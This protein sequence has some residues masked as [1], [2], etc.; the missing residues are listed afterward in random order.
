MK[1]LPF[2]DY[3]YV[4]SSESSDNNI[5]QLSGFNKVSGCHVMFRYIPNNNNNNKN[6]LHQRQEQYCSILHNS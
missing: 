5:L 2:A 6:Y 1:L 3:I 4:E